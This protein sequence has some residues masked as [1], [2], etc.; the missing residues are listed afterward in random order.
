VEALQSLPCDA[1]DATRLS[2]QATPNLLRR[3]EVGLYVAK[4]RTWTA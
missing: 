4:K 3:N 1:F 2:A